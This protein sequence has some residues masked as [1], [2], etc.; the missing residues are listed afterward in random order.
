MDVAKGNFS[1]NYSANIRAAPEQFQNQS[2]KVT[3]LKEV[4][5]KWGIPNMLNR[6]ILLDI[7]LSQLSY[8]HGQSM[9][10]DKF[11]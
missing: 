7:L 2:Q 1:V 9:F 8:Q 4:S 5:N 10:P 11:G 3:R 6:Y